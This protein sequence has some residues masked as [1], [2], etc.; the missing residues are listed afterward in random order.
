MPILP[1]DRDRPKGQFAG[2]ALLAIGETLVWAGLFYVFAAMFLSW[3]TDLGWSKTEISLGIT[4]AILTSAACAPISGRII[5]AGYGRFLLSVGAIVGA[6]GL[7][8]LAQLSTKAGFLAAWVLIGATQSATLYEPCFSFV[9]RTLGGNA[10]PTITRITLVAGFAS[11]LCFPAAAVLNGAY[12]WR[13]TLV[14]FACVVAFIAAPALYFGA[15]LLEKATT[16]PALPH[17]RA[18]NKAA[19]KRVMARREFWLL[20]F[21]FGFVALNHGLI[22]N[23]VLPIFVDRGASL[24]A[25]TAA[26]SLIGPAQVLG[27]VMMLSVERRLNSVPLAIIAITTACTASLVLFSARYLPEL[28]FLFA[29]LQGCAFGVFSILRPVMVAEILG[30]AAFGA[31]S[32][33]SSIPYL[34]AVA[35]SPYIASLIWQAAG[36]DL[37]ILFALA[38]SLIGLIAVRS[39]RHAAQP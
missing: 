27:R 26:A 9:T 7:L 11:T 17:V 15:S 18:E 37:V 25:A 2:V 32:A 21:G 8:M 22:L 30:R 19:V 14:L 38:T 13:V 3:E 29:V 20:A 36:Y 5:D 24:W 4:L 16:T 12:G 39:L 1:A 35:L 28:I 23:H 34:V 10:R 31:V 6:L 33:R